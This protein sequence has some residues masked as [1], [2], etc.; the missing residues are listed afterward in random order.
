MNEIVFAITVCL[1]IFA[2]I[3]VAFLRKKGEKRTFVQYA[4][5]PNKNR[6][7]TI[8]LTLTS[9]IVGG[10][11]FLAV[12]QMGYE[13]KYVGMVLGIVYI[14]GLGLVGLFTKKIRRLMEKQHCLTLL[15]FLSFNYDKKV[16]AQFTAVNFVMYLFLL[17]SQFVAMSQLLS[18]MQSKMI[19]QFIPYFLVGLAVVALFLYPIIGGI[20]KDIQTDIIQMLVLFIAAFFI[21]YQLV[22]K[23]AFLEV[24]NANHFA[25]PQKNNY[26]IIFI[27]G[28]IFFLTPSFFVR[29]DMWQRIN[30]AKTSKDAKYGFW[31]AGILS[32]VFFVLFTLIGSYANVLKFE[33]GQFAS[34][35]TLFTI[36]D[37]P[38]L[39]GFIIGAFFSAVLSSADTLI[40]NVSIF[41]TKLFFPKSNFSIENSTSIKLLKFSRLSA[42]ILTLIAIVISFIMPDIV[43]LLIGAFSLLLIFFPTI[44][45]LL[46][47]HNNSNAAFYSA[48]FGL[49]VF[50]L[51]FF[52]WNPKLAFIPAIISSFIVYFCILIVKKQERVKNES[53]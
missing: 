20:R 16:I 28:S 46:L 40:N 30:T 24:F 31:I 49:T 36:F 26:G 14:I 34:I 21:I 1:L 7:S 47:K 35:N 53:F 52:L 29:M 13:S 23:N 33:E 10:G 12:G 42:I 37:N 39:L 41:A 4:A 18:F 6:F 48:F 25:S 38:I 8:A 45:G 17:S 2:N 32:F 11:M 27:I 15:D 19:C 50:L 3:I 44:L 22:N 5:D 43:D 51:C 9:T